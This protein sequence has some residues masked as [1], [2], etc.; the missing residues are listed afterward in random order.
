DFSTAPRPVS[1][2][3]ERI[4]SHCLE[5]DPAAR[6]QS[7]Q[8]VAFNLEA[9]S[10]LSEPSGSVP[11]PGHRGRRALRP[12]PALALLAALLAAFAIGRYLH[13]GGRSPPKYRQLT[14]RKGA[15]YNARFTPDGQSYVFTAAWKGSEYE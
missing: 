8:D 7:A 4:V 6:F 13:G 12:L 10:G 3:L 11:R 1:P 14:F 9:L 5:K 15:V 2:A